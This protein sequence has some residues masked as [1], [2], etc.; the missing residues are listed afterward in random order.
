MKQL[1][2]FLL[3][4]LCQT[5]V[6]GEHVMRIEVTNVIPDRGQVNVAL[7]DSDA[8]YLSRDD[9]PFRAHSI[10][11]ESDRVAVVFDKLPRGRYAVTI[12]QDINGNGDLDGNLVGL[13]KEPYGFSN[14]PRMIF[15]PPSFKK[16]AFEVSEDLSIEVKLR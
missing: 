8:T 11:S 3:L 14:N 10:T 5:A 12:Y 9:E 4:M 7:H 2:K 6:A 1:C 13:P 16:A 15:G